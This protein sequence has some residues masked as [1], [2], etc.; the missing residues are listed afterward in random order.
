[1]EHSILLFKILLPSV[2]TF[3]LAI[4]V[5]PFFSNIFYKYRMWKRSSRVATENTIGGLGEG[6]SSEFKEVYNDKEVHT[7][8]VGGII[9]WF[10]VSVVI[11]LASTLSSLIDTPWAHK[12]LFLTREQTLIPF[13]SLLLGAGLGLVD[14]LLQ[15]YGRTKESLTL[16]IPR[17]IRIAF[18]LFLGALEGLWFYHK[19]GY[20]SIPLPFSDFEI[21][22]GF[23]FVF[24]FMFVVLALFS[25]SV[26]DGIDGLAPGVL[27]IIFGTYGFIGLI[28]EQY[29]IAAF[30]FVVTGA[31]LA[32]LWFNIP[33]ARFYLG[34]TGILSLTLSLAVLIFLTQT[35]VEFII[36]GFP[37]VATSASSL[38]QIISRRFFG[39]KVFRV[40]PLHHHF[41]SLG[42]SREKI[43]M[44][45]WVFSVFCSLIGIIIIS[46]K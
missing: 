19:L 3:L 1:M 39:K 32:F 36:I 15:I 23:G 38:I 2:L 34:E 42:W 44:R 17:R 5:T 43:T 37:L 31:L 14:D 27:S 28:Q 12:L 7:P 20:E 9:V 18:I 8:R 16:G 35:V 33:P 21:V 11:V 22:L 29:N 40:A 26:I 41:E 46:L 10:S 4:F 6:V 24:F 25:S 30:A 45:Y 13:M